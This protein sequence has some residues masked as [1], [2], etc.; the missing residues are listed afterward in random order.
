[1]KKIISSLVVALLLLCFFAVPTTKADGENTMGFKLTSNHSECNSTSNHVDVGDTFYYNIYLNVVQEIDTVTAV[2]VT[3]LPAGI[4]NITG[5]SSDD[6]KKGDIFADFTIWADPWDILEKSAISN[7]S[8]YAKEWLGCG[9][10]VNN[11][12]K[13]AFNI[14]WYAYSAGTATLTVYGK[15]AEAGYN[16]PTVNNTATVYVYPKQPTSVSVEGYSYQRI[17]L[18][19]TKG[20]GAARTVIRYRTDGNYPSSP[21]DGT[22]LYND[23]GS[24]TQHT[25]ITEGQT[26]HYSIWSYANGMFSQ[27]PI[28]YNRTTNSSVVFGTPSPVNKSVDRPN[29]L[30]WNISISDPDGDTFN[31]TIQC[32]NTQSASANGAS[33]GT[34]SLYLDVLEYNMNYTVWVNATDINSKKST[35]ATFW[36]ETLENLG[37]LDPVLVGPANDSDY[38]GV[39]NLWMNV[40][41]EDPEDDKLEIAYFWQN[42]TL[43]DTITN[44]TSNTTASLRIGCATMWPGNTTGWLQHNTTYNWYVVVDDLDPYGEKIPETGNKT[45]PTWSFHTSMAADINEDRDVDYLD[46]SRLVSAYGETSTP[47]GRKQADINNDGTIGVGDVSALLVDYGKSF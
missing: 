21:T 39:Y 35:N 30:W 8:G 46:A 32:N 11:T 27:N 7:E 36:F 37:P 26:V 15:T 10:S 13:T 20:N 42:G 4:I 24:S 22:N 12:N 25:G 29:K 9:T 1:M 41:V 28:Q 23:T 40:T 34:K 18:S 17:D 31:W 2:N 45:S 5:P 16:V 3:F 14:E 44:V 19:W 43:I 38:V 47:H 33:N 6:L